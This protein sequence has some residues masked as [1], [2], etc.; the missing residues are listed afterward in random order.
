MSTV[1]DVKES[2]SLGQAGTNIRTRTAARGFTVLFDA[3]SASNPVDAKTAD[4]IPLVQKDSH[5]DDT[6]LVATDCQVRM[7][8]PV[9]AEV[10]VQYGTPAV[11]GFRTIVGE[12]GESQLDLNP[13]ISIV[14]R[15]EVVEV[16]CDADGAVIK[17]ANGDP[18]TI[19]RTVSDPMLVVRRYMLSLDPNLILAYTSEGGAVNSDTFYGAKPGRALLTKF[20]ATQLYFG[21]Y[22]YI[23]AE[24]NVVFRKGT[25]E[26]GLTDD[27]VAEKAWYYRHAD[28]G[29]RV[30]VA[31]D[32]LVRAKVNPDD[33]GTTNGEYSPVPVFLNSDGTRASAGTVGH[34]IYTKRYPSLPFAPLGII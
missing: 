8:S 10:V 25:P 13:Q 34:W 20:E 33:D 1:I 19:Q 22:A 15:E 29:F 31:G 27:Q 12:D 2:W 14:P 24:F 18:I 32:T 4:G 28:K 26:S 11:A 9:L 23:E 30:K 21:G 5:P 3:P 7:L 16:E 17:N 6:F